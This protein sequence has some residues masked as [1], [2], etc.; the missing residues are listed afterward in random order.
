M[1]GEEMRTLIIDIG[2]YMIK[3]GYA[4]EEKP[5]D[6][7]PTIIGHPIKEKENGNHL[8][9]FVGNDAIQKRGI[10]DLK[11]PYQKGRIKDWKEMEEIFDHLF[12]NHAKIDPSTSNIFLTES[13]EYTKEDREK[14]VCLMFETFEAQNVYLGLQQRLALMATSGG[15]TGVVLDCGYDTCYTVPI[16]EGYVM[17]H[18]ITKMEMGGKDISSYLMDLLNEAGNSLTTSSEREF[19]NTLKE[20]HCYVAFDYENG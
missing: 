18:G 9:R 14:L 13:P 17:Y 11:Y 8:T 10:L 3:L 5:R 19:V 6:Y 16:Y 12:K 7:V 2:S 4:G 20:S 1:D 15:S